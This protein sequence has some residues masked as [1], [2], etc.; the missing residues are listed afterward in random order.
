MDRKWNAEGLT[1]QRVRE[2][3]DYDPATGLFRW[4]K[5]TSNRVKIGDVA[6]VKGVNGYI[7]LAID[8]YRLLAHRV[9]RLYVFGDWP[10]DQIDHINRDRSDNRL[11]NLRLASVSDNACNGR[12][13]STNT[14]GFRGVS[15]IKKNTKRPWLAQIVKDGRQY[16]LGYYATKEE[17]YDAYRR[18][19]AEL[20]G[21]FA[22]D[23][24]E[25]G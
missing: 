16:G 10:R 11:E 22:S 17:A 15:L 14:S 21:R 19:A 12:L 1:Q 20:H 9:V 25:I 6:G 23:G 18:A 8:N 2:L 4:K 7:Y 13:R 24:K 3:L 5:R